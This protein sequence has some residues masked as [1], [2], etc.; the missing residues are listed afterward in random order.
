MKFEVITS[1]NALMY[2]MHEYDNPQ[3][4]SMD[5]FMEDYKRLKYIKR[6]CRRYLSTKRLSERLMLNHVVLLLNV[7]GPEATVRLLF[8]KC[9]DSRMFAVLKP[10]LLYLDVLPQVVS[11]VNGKSI[12]TTPIPLDQKLVKQLEAL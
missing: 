2:A 8:L 10:F 6:L 11:G 1:K 3:C 5:E 9:D 4:L 7:F 12:Q